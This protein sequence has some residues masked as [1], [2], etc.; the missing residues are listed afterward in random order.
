MAGSFKL[1]EKSI[2]ARHQ[3]GNAKFRKSTK[4]LNKVF[5]FL[6]RMNFLPMFGVGRSMILLKT[7][8]RKTGKIR[9]TPVLCKVFHTGELTLYSARGM[10]ADWLRNILADDKKQTDIQKGFKRM[11]VQAKLIEPINEKEEHLRYWFE[12]LN[13]AKYIFGYDRNKHGNVTETEE[14]KEIAKNIEFIQLI[15]VK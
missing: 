2:V 3:K 15:P 11:R 5:S 13:D 14:F 1:S 10:K 8:G 4:R 6:Y 12:N 9:I 7:V